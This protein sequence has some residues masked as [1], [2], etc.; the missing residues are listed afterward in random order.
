MGEHSAF[1]ATVYGRVQGVNFRAF[2]QRCARALAISGYV[3]NMP[4]GRSVEVQAEGEKDK[5]DR[6]IE[7]LH[8]GP[9][10]AR[11]DRVEVA[12]KE[13]ENKFTGF[14]IRY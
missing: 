9:E 11:V 12:W 8:S 5:L 13:P 1:F 4:D 7:L 2:V 6:L 14:S 3:K 10:G